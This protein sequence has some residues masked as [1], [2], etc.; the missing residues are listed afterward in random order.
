M[1]KRMTVLLLILA[2]TL[3]TA[4]A[5]PAKEEEKGNRLDIAFGLFS[6]ELPQ[7]VSAGHNTGNLLSDHRYELE[8]M[9]GILYANCSPAEEYASTAGKRLD[10]L[11]S[12]VFA[13]TGG[14]WEETDIREERPAGV[15][16]RWQS[17]RAE[18]KNVLW[19][20]AFDDSF[21]YNVC[22]EYDPGIPDDTVLAM[23]RSFRANAERERDL[24]EVRQT[25]PEQGTFV[26]TEHGLMLRLTRDWKPV[27][28]EQMI[29]PNTAFVLEKGAG[30]W[31]IELLRTVPA[32][33]ED[34]RGM[35]EDLLESRGYAAEASEPHAVLLKYLGGTEAW[36]SEVDRN[37][38]ML[39]VA[40]VHEGYGYY[41]LF[42]WV[43]ADD[44]EARPFMTAALESIASP[45]AA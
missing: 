14:N 24:L 26:S 40:F 32:G 22:L 29:H 30:R 15:S 33:P 45:E 35:L 1:R 28:Q 13:L 17:L 41:G 20:E 44:A 25:Q 37:V 27:T 5:G 9:D 42:M 39:H 10:S 18:T 38:I 36:V 19:F 21:G 31:M 8:G 7:G 23:M 11:L 43:A 6:L 16:L 3:S 4:C 34:A 2:L 12:A